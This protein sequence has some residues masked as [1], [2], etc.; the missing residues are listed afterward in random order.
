MRKRI[1][2]AAL[3]VT[4]LFTG[5]T[6]VPD[7]SRLQR[8]MEAEYMAAAILR[9][10]A[11]YDEML[12]YDRS[13]LTATPTPAPTPK[14]SP[15]ATGQEETGNPSN[16]PDDVQNQSQTFVSLEELE[17]VKGI[18]L[19]QESYQLKKSYG[20]D[21]A[22]VTAGEN[23]QLLIVKF[24]L[25]NNGSGK[26]QVEMAE[27]GLDFS[28][29]IDGETLGSP[30]MTMLQEDLQFYHAGIS[31]GK[32]REA[33]LVFEIPASQKVKNASL[34]ISNQKQTAQISLK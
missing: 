28:L 1:C 8:D 31:A 22:M 7:L 9:H 24:R 4:V 3:S 26:K 33:V 34:Y 15:G 13:I 30:K 6:Q 21:F 2:V 11:N 20:S 12:E 16:T 5:C 14:R 17:P 10:S 25:K 27:S 23:K 19:S 29:E 18:T 32:S